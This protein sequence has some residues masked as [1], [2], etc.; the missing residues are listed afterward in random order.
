M[1]INEGGYKFK[2]SET[3]IGIAVPAEFDLQRKVVEDY[4]AT[5][6]RL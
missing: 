6:D 3:G 4:V 5:I 1:F 2:S